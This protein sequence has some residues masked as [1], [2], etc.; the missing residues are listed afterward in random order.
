MGSSPKSP[1]SSISSNSNKNKLIDISH[2]IVELIYIYLPMVVVS[3]KE[4]SFI[5]LNSTKKDFLKFTQEKTRL[6][7]DMIDKIF[8]NINKSPVIYF[9]AVSYDVYKK[10][11]DKHIHNVINRITFMNYKEFIKEIIYTSFFNDLRNILLDFFNYIQTNIKIN[12]KISDP[13]IIDIVNKEIL[14]CA[15][16]GYVWFNDEKNKITGAKNINLFM[17]KQRNKVLTHYEYIEFAA[18]MQNVKTNEYR[19]R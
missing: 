11:H 6:I 12:D 15:I 13:N 2:Y 7:K 8:V 10:E 19:R 1:N 17:E 16:G 3:D 4:Y 14:R 18:D 5:I 9:D